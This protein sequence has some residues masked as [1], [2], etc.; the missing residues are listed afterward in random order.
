MVVLRKEVAPM[1]CSDGRRP[2]LYF[3]VLSSFNIEREYGLST[4][5]LSA[6]G[7]VVGAIH[8]TCV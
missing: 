5:R 7:L 3:P 6:F 4:R 8:H 1:W 2:A